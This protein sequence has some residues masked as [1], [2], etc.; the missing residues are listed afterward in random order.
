M[1]ADTALKRYSAMNLSAPWRGL[2]VSPD[3]TIPAGE[4]AAA[5][6]YYGGGFSSSGRVAGLGATIIFG[7]DSELRVSTSV[8]IGGF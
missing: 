3:V 5:F 2:N 6:Y 8:G 1:A 7:L 4:R